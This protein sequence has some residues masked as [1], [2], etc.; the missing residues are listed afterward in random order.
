MDSVEVLDDASVLE[1]ELIFSNRA[2]ENIGPDGKLLKNQL[3]YIKRGD[4]INNLDEIIKTEEI[5]QKLV[6][7]TVTYTNKGNQRLDHICYFGNMLLINETDDKYQIYKYGGG[8]CDLAGGGYD[9]I[10]ETG[11]SGGEMIY[12]SVRT[13]YG[14]GGNYISSLEPGESTQVKMAW[15]TNEKNLG[16]MYL[17]L[18]ATGGNIEFDEYMKATGIVDIRQ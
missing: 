10:E 16:N 17:N 14:M 6:L 8:I 7:T 2:K 1:P 4:G 18:C 9:D 11:L 3:S 5:D 15:I 12:G 13:D